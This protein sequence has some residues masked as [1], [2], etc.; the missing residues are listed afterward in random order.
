MNNLALLKNSLFILILIASIW[1]FNLDIFDNLCY[2]I[3]KL[4][5]I[6]ASILILWTTVLY[7]MEK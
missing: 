2:I 6:T 4:S 7:R 1:L 3:G 5:L